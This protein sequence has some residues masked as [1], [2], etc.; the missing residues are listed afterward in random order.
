MTLAK[1]TVFAFDSPPLF[2]RKCL[3]INKAF[4]LITESECAGEPFESGPPDT[5]SG[6]SK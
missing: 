6:A 5:H 3:F 1:K 4:Y 2:M